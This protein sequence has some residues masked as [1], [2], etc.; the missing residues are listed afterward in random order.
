MK[1]SLYLFITLILLSCG[2]SEENPDNID[3][4]TVFETSEGTQTPTY[5][6]VIQFYKDLDEAYTS[7]RTYEMDDT[8]TDS[9]KPLD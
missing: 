9:N 7:I 5:P 3:F 8:D 1:N 4:T 6:E 2:S